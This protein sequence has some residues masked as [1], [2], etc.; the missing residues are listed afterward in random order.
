MAK[1]VLAEK[2]DMVPHLQTILRDTD[3]KLTQFSPENIDRL[4]KGIIVKD[5]KGAI[6]LYTTCLIRQKE[7]K[8]TPEEI[9][10]QLYIIRL[11]EE[12]RYPADRFQLEYPVSFGRERKKLMLSFLK[13]ISPLRRISL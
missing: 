8:L 1:M 4:E 12:H 10:R 9:V 3:Y 6:S 5:S 2:V 7:I 13:K 11:M